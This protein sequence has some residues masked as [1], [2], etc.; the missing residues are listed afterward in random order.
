M[1]HSSPHLA[2]ALTAA[3]LLFANPPGVA[4]AEIRVGVAA[5][6]ITPPMGIPMAGYYHE[7]GA[8]GVLDPLFSK[9]MVIESGGERAALVTLDI[10]SVTRA[11]TDQ[12]RAAIENATGIKGE[13]VMIS[14]T[15]AHTGPEL[16]N[17]GKKSSDMGG[18]HQLTVDYTE[19]LPARIAESVRLATANLQPAQLSAAKGRCE[20]LTFNRR[21]YMRDGSVG[22]NPG[23][24]TSSVSY[25]SVADAWTNAYT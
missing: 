10:I 11:I 2:L 17:R 6:D 9:A 3:A 25:V 24:L 19:G 8:D 1:K 18:Q 23:K 14:A 13:H 20:E 7:H 16:A 4:A 21:F 5:T 12:A 22:W 15:H